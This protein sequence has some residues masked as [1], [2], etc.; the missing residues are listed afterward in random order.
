LVQFFGALFDR[1]DV[2][3]IRPIESWSEGG[4]KR[5]RVF[6]RQIKYGRV[7]YF[8]SDAAYWRWLLAWA[9]REKANL[10]FTI[11]PR[12]GPS[13]TRDSKRFDL[14]WQIRVV[15]VLWAD[16]DHCTPEEALKRCQV[17][18][19]PSPSVVV[20]SGNGV[21][22]YWVLS[23]PYLIDDADEPPGICTE[24]IEQGPG[25]KKLTR[26]LY[27]TRE[28][29]PVYL[30]LRDPK[31]GGDTKT[32]NPDCPWG[33]LSP[34]AKHIQDVLAGL[35]SRIG[36]DHTT[37]LARLLRLPCTF[38]RKNQRN[39]QEPVP[40]VLVECH[41]ERRYVFADFE[42]LAAFSAQKI[43]REKIAAIQL[44]TGR[45]LSSS[46]RRGDRFRNLINACLLAE[47][48]L[49]SERDF[50]L[51]A[52]C[53]EQGVSA[54][55]VWSEVQGIGKFAEHGRPYF[56]RTWRKAEEE[57]RQTIY[58]RQL[59]RSAPPHSRNGI[60]KPATMIDHG[61]VSPGEGDLPPPHEG[62]YEDDN[63][64]NHVYVPEELDDPHALARAWVVLRGSREKP[65]DCM[66][67][68][69]QQFWQWREC[70]WLPAPDHELDAHLTHFVRRQLEE[71][72]RE[73]S[74]GGEENE[75]EDTIP[76][77]TRKLVTDVR[78]AL[79]G[80]I[81]VPDAVPQPSWRGD[82]PGLRN[83]IA[84]Q[85]GLLD[86]EA[87]LAGEQEVMRP[88]T[89]FWFSPFCLP[90][91]FDPTADCPT[92]R[93]FLAR[94]FEDDP[95]KAL[96]L[97]QWAGYLLVPDTTLQRFL[98]MVGE[99]KNGKSVVCEVITAL[100]GEDNVSTVP[101]ELFG[102]KFRLFGTLGKLA[103][104]TAE[105]GELDKVVEGQVKAFVVGDAMEFE[106]KFKQPF[107]ARPTARLMLAT[108]NAPQFSDKS[109]G[110]WRRA[111][112]L[113]F[114]VQISDSERIIGMDKREFWQNLGE[115]PGILNWAL[116]G[117][118]ALRTQRDFVV[119]ASCREALNKLRIDS[120]PAK[121]FLLEHYS[122][123]DGDVRKAQ[124]YQ[125]Y[126]DWCKSHGHHALAEV[127]FGKEVKRTFPAAKDGKTS[128]HTTG[129]RENTYTGLS[130]LPA[131]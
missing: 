28:G 27:Y 29:E 72:F 51:C 77:V 32:L 61:P 106:R 115:L 127:G 100:L 80:E 78:G 5:S 64:H 60:S 94:N 68:Y 96:L 123:G 55:E 113:P 69:R 89:P 116:A 70:R 126:V 99:G 103:N 57:T 54:E 62:D 31:T 34:K 4:R 130:R 17:A 81:L 71:A 90:Y 43:Q 11:C 47:P 102:D 122:P 111:L 84:V 97:Q 19:L 120:N 74:S 105:V 38:N 3:G 15:R 49:R 42:G 9:E 87:F 20:N 48:G 82:K 7:R 129:R 10:Y 6:Y 107:T 73:R 114:S 41:P 45:K 108:N 95:G 35:A 117:L 37:D 25:K 22:L 16:L 110:I 26:K 66:A 46:A 23:E 58:E 83:W 101:L 40:C 112:L 13:H 67:F 109:E 128:S 24:F 56:D 131:D 121:R 65:G 79:A 119:P 8:T 2:I 44:P 91:P 93:A 36:G 12:V 98:M 75:K 59:R 118:H 63:D 104:I 86:V 88:H 30:Y 125:E 92:W 1:L 39:G 50:H 53:V 14:A 124:L 18:G 21:H 76:R 85:N 33:E 52:W